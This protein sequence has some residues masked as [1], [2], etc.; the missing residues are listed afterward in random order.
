[1]IHRI[2]RVNPDV[3]DRVIKPNE[4]RDAINLRFGASTEDT[5]LSGGTLILGNKELPFVPPTGTNRVVGVYSD[6]ESRNVYF[7]L[8]NSGGDHGLYRINGATDLVEPILMGSWLNFEGQDEYNVSIAVIDGKLYFT[9]NVNPPRMVNI[10]KGVRTQKGDGDDVY[11]TP[12]EDW[13][14]TQIKRPPGEVLVVSPVLNLD[15]RSATIQNKTQ[16]ETGLQYSYYYVYDNF[17][18]SRLGPFTALNW[19]TENVTITIPES[20]WN[21]YGRV[22]SMIRAI[23][24]VI[25]NGND[26]VWRELQ[27]QK[28][29]GVVREWTFSNVLT[30]IK[31]TV[32]SDITDARFDS[33]PL[34]SVTNEVA[35][36]RVNH[37]NYVLDYEYDTGIT[38]EAAIESVAIA[39]SDFGAFFEQNDRRIF[40]AI[41]AGN[42]QYNSFV[43]WGRYTI[44]VELVDKFGRTYPVTNTTEVVAAILNQ[45][46]VNLNGNTFNLNGT[47]SNNTVVLYES[48]PDH[49]NGG[50][51][52][53][54]G[55]GQDDNNNTVCPYKITLKNNT[56]PDWVS[57][58]NIVRSKAKNI[59]S[60]N[61][62]IGQ[63]FLWY[64]N[65]KQ[66]ARFFVTVQGKFYYYQVP[67]NP[68]NTDLNTIWS[69]DE[70]KQ[71][72]KY[73]FKGYVIFFNNGEPFN[74]TGNQ[75]VTI[76]NPY[77]FE[78]LD[79]QLAYND[80][81]YGKPDENDAGRYLN[82]LKFPVY[83]INNQFIFIKADAAILRHPNLTS[84]EP[85]IN[86]TPY[87]I[88]VAVFGP[89]TD[90]FSKAKNP[91]NVYS[92]F[93]NF[94]LTTEIN[95]DDQTVYTTQKTYTKQEFETEIKQYN[96]VKGIITGDAS[97]SSV[98]KV[99][100]FTSRPLN[101][102]TLP[103]FGESPTIDPDQPIT[104]NRTAWYGTFI[105]MSP[106]DIYAQ[107]WNQDIGQENV[108]DYKD[109]RNRRLNSSICF[110]LPIVQGTQVNGLNKFNS[111]D[112]RLAP[113]ENG[114]ITAL[115]TTNATQREPGILLAIGTYG[116]SS[117]Y[118]D[119]I[120]L[121]NVDGSNNVTTTDSYLASQRPLLGQ[122]GSSRPMS[123]TKTPL[124]TVYW[125]SD[126]VNDLIRYTN[127]GL[128]RLGLTYSFGNFL[129]RTYNDNSLLITWYDQMTD[130]IHLLGKEKNTAV[131][132]ER[133]KTFQGQREYFQAI[134]EDI[135]LY[136]ERA[137]GLPT[138][139]YY[140]IEGR[141]YVSD[142]EAQG[143]A[144]NFLF[145]GFKNPSL[146]IVTNEAPA[147][148]KQWNQIKVFGAKPTGVELSCPADSGG[149]PLESA[150]SPSHFIER[151]GDYEAAIRRATNT[152]GGLLAGKIMESRII[153][154][155][156]AFDANTF[157]KLNFVEV[158]GNNSIVQ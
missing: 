25:R 131:F 98:N 153:Y 67:E 106:R 95:E 20:E 9:D 151:K 47:A 128:E 61:Q 113:A 46:V 57:R 139:Q 8:Y 15:Q 18:E 89:N 157:V 66:E 51:I 80:Y 52:N 127:A 92:L 81:W 152:T 6:L 28:N 10:E 138:K 129:R 107:T 50:Y 38:V 59:V 22:S 3:D 31:N 134:K 17:E 130:E 43:P 70:D 74:N 65:E 144:N 84:A 69:K 101:L 39:G 156:F 4:A 112:F 86:L 76:Y 35:Q 75:Y 125:W 108:T 82:Y 91:T 33:V 135:L 100:P 121:T 19:A 27:Y 90:S 49:N 21:A 23:V 5:N 99:Y 133:Y 13:H 143:V 146:T 140:F 150:L 109:V 11:P 53:V 32:A 62:S 71:N 41:E 88:P 87:S 118:Y 40:N 78:I 37:G 55:Y 1:M 63:V 60:M 105:S 149:V 103:K 158:K 68:R 141:I 64:E 16:T 115:V 30:A 104:M 120:Q 117:F 154:S 14:Y 12:V 124:G 111:L 85:E 132:S 94:T 116:V 26:G 36:N 24:I 97:M 56:L 155:K 83:T 73:T 48:S 45:K 79:P 142:V 34:L 72:K 123:V 137:T 147:S 7:A 96:S 93:Y 2:D 126:V 145:G 119:A 42:L 110:S 148:V 136:P 114:P 54:V 44:G 29:E 102:Y 77:S 58:V 122:Y